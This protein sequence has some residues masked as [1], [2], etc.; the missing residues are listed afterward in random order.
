MYTKILV[1]VLILLVII[2]YVNYYTS[3]KSDYNIMQTYLDK[4]DISI[5]YEKYPVII[6]DRLLKPEDLTQTLF[7]YSYIFKRRID[8]NAPVNPI[9]NGSKHM[10]VWSPWHDCT[11]NVINPKYKKQFE[12]K[13]IKGIKTSINPL[14]ES[15][16]QYVTVKLKKYQVAIIPAFWIIDSD[17][18]IS[19]IQLDDFLSIWNRG[20]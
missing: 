5:I 19:V 17:V 13:K 3:Y 11:I 15:S 9:Y 1:G 6:Y 4:V 7:A 10:L 14:T 2:I 16:V 12:W 8:L 20:W 18:D